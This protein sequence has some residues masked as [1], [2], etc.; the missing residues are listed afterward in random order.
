MKT[1]TAPPA[2]VS[3]TIRARWWRHPELPLAAIVLIAWVA[4]GLDHWAG[5]GS[6]EEPS[7][8]FSVGS[9]T[10]MSIAMMGPGIAPMYRWVAFN[11][12]WRRRHRSAALFAVGFVTIWVAFG[13]ALVAIVRIGAATAGRSFEPDRWWVA[14]SLAASAIWH[15]APARKRALR[16]CHLRRP[17]AARGW[18]SDAAAVRYG[19]FVAGACAVSCGGVMVAMFI[20]A[21]DFHLMVPLTAIVLIER[22]QF[23]PDE[24]IG[25]VAVLCVAA[26]SLVG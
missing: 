14:G 1:V 11:S 17:L 21:H 9:W 19:V 26:V 13:L 6:S 20:G 2:P 8:R 25:A 18:R 10:L 23:R 5:H 12:L 16:R 24:R 7:W 15:L 22:F 3:V 4:L